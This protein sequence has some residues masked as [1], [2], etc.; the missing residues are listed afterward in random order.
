M[1]Q[2]EHQIMSTRLKISVIRNVEIG[3]AMITLMELARASASNAAAI[4]WNVVLETGQT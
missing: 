3:T 1:Y 4:G 2:T